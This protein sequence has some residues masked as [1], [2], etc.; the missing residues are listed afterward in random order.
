MCSSAEFISSPRCLDHFSK[1]RAGLALRQPANQKDNPP[2]DG[3]ED[4]TKNEEIYGEIVN[5]NI[6]V[7]MLEGGEIMLS[8]QSLNPG[9]YGKNHPL[10]ADWAKVAGSGIRDEVELTYDPNNN[11]SI[12]SLDV[13]FFRTPE[14]STFEL[15]LIATG[16]F[17]LLIPFCRRQ[18]GAAG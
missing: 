13:T 16:I 8:W 6:A 9:A 5:G 12:T 7:M 10:P 14:P 18:A 2:F 4:T 15:T 11:N 3:I 17:G 1:R